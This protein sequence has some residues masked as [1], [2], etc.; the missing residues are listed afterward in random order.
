M[1]DK[2]SYNDED[3]DL[4]KIRLVELNER[5]YEYR[6]LKDYCFEDGNRVSDEYFHILTRNAE[7]HDPHA[8]MVLTSMYMFDWN[9]FDETYNIYAMY[10]RR[11]TDFLFTWGKLKKIGI[12]DIYNLAKAERNERVQKSVN[13]FLRLTDTIRQEFFFVRNGKDLFAHYDEIQNYVK[14]CEDHYFTSIWVEDAHGHYKLG[15][16][17]K[18]LPV[19]D[20]EEFEL[21]FAGRYA[22]KAYHYFMRVMD[23]YIAPVSVSEL[24]ESIQDKLELKKQELDA[25]RAE[26]EKRKRD[27]LTRQQ[28]LKNNK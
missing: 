6:L 23:K 8:L 26:L 25:K 4:W 9:L 13:Q 5:T 28:Q 10:L 16:G 7:N 27:L 20:G 19:L 2:V 11:F 14:N 12:K 15:E 21:T 24:E 3:A 1:G 18:S 22:N 17:S